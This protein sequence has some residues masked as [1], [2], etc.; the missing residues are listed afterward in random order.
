MAPADRLRRLAAA[1][2]IAALALAS[3]PAAALAGEEV[4]TDLEGRRLEAGD[5]GRGRV[6]AVFMA[7]WSPRCRDVVARV[8]RIERR[9]GDKARVVLIDFQED[10]Q[11][12]RA[13]LDGE[14]TVPVYLD[15][16]GAFS[17]EHAIT[18]LPGLLVLKDGAVA[19]RG[20]LSGDPDDVL[21]QILG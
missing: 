10:A 2:L 4:L 21:S 3:A 7:T 20:R 16:D 12:V 11:T 13:F 8:E 9:W 6:I 19:F 1:G 5:F 15:R 18:F 14:A 17:K